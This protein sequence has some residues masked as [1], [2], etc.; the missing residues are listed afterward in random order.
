MGQ[1]HFTPIFVKE[2]AYLQGQEHVT[3]IFVQ[4]CRQQSEELTKKDLKQAKL[5]ILS[6]L[7]LQQLVENKKKNY[8]GWGS[9][10]G[11]SS[12]EGEHGSCLSHGSGAR[13][14]SPSSHAKDQSPHPEWAGENLVHK[15]KKKVKKKTLLLSIQSNKPLYFLFQST[16]CNLQKI[17]NLPQLI[18]GGISSSCP[19]VFLSISTSLIAYVLSLS[20]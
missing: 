12:H 4:E 20:F 17:K 11:Q 6:A 13:Y 9:G 5:I 15:K 1:K 10:W 3:T 14:T 16:E 8:G 19:C 7:Y 2:F 18:I